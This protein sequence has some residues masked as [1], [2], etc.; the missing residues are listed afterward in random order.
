M[1]KTAPVVVAILVLVLPAAAAAKVKAPEGSYAGPRDLVMQ[2]S[3][4]T[5]DILAFN[6]PCKKHPKSHGRTSLNSIPLRKASEGYKF[7]IKLRGIVTFSDGRADENGTFAIS[8]QFG[9]RGR[10]AHGRFMASVRHCG[11][12]GKLKWSAERVEGRAR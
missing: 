8:G 4:K 11:P 10:S 6:F 7:S 5:I 9:R 1:R 3:D 2:I 12:T